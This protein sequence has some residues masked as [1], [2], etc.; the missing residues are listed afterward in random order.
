MPFVMLSSE[1]PKNKMLIVNAK[2]VNIQMIDQSG[3]FGVCLSAKPKIQR[4]G[5]MTT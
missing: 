1:K 4:A 2:K 3:T 5:M